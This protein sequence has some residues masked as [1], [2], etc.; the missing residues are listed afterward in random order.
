MG[1]QYFD[2]LRFGIDNINMDRINLQQFEVIAK[3]LGMSGLT[4]SAAKMVLLENEMGVTAARITGLTPQSVSNTVKRYR[5][6]D[7]SIRRA[8]VPKAPKPND[9]I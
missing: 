5:D 4:K 1:L 3:L 9:K 2:E 6:A 8:Y 7:A